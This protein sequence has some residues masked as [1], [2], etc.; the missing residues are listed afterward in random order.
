M[1]ST[2]GG[3]LSAIGKALQELVKEYQ[4]VGRSLWDLVES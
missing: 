1:A 4:G 3:V 2:Y